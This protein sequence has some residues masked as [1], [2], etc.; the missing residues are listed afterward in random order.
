MRSEIYIVDY[1]QPTDHFYDRIRKADATF[2]WIALVCKELEK[3]AAL[4]ILKYAK[5]FPATLTT[6]YKRMLK[7]ILEQ[8]EEEAALQLCARASCVARCSHNGH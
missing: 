3:D 8:D 6:L 4:R 2:L 5:A 7:Q 1:G